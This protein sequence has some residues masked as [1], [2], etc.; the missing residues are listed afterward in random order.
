M[1]LKQFGP[2]GGVPLVPFDPPPNSTDTIQCAPSRPKMF[3]NSCNILQTLAKLYA[4]PPRG[5]APNTENPGSAPVTSHSGSCQ[6][7]A[8]LL[9]PILSFSCSFLAKILPNNRFSAE[10]QGLVSLLG[11]LGS[12]T[13]LYR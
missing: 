9:G 8:S 5:S 7:R 4:G 6:A 2:P 3:S 13:K 10:I 12:A 11:N 1:K